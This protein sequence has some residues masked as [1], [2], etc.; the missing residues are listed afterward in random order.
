MPAFVRHIR[1]K[2]QT[3]SFVS[4]AIMLGSVKATAPGINMTHNINNQDDTPS[5]PFPTDDVLS[6]QDTRSSFADTTFES[7]ASSDNRYLGR[8]M[9]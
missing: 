2:A 3:S 6:L 9:V 7:K 5:K 4:S 1:E 8:A